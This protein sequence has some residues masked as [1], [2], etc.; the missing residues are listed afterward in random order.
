MVWMTPTGQKALQV[1]GI[2]VRKMFLKA[3]P[4]SEVRV[5]DD[6]VKIRELLHEWQ[7]RIIRPEYVFMGPV[8]EG[9]VQMWDNWVR[10]SNFCVRNQGRNANQLIECLPYCR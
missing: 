2:A 1:H 8:E 10:N 4:T 7:E 3:T 9:D 5:V 6:V